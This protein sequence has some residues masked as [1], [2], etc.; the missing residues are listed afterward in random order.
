M[1][2]DLLGKTAM[3]KLAILPAWPSRNSNNSSMILLLRKQ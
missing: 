1:R 3:G 2:I